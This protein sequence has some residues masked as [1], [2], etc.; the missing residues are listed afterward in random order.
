MCYNK[1]HIKEQT[2]DKSWW[3]KTLKE[4]LLPDD[5]REELITEFIEFCIEVLGLKDIEMDFDFTTNRSQTKTYAHYSPSDN[6]IVVYVG[7]RNLGDILRST[8]HEMVHAKQNQQGKLKENS[9]RTG[10]PEEN[11]ANTAAGI[12]MREF[13]RIHPEIF[14]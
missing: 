4:E 8:A 13:G 6:N 11:A 7:N 12:L 14:E 10:S 2:F 5:K 3:K 1:H 9:G